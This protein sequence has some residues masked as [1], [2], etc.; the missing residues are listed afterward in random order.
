VVKAPVD[1][2]VESVLDVTCKVLNVPVELVVF[3]VTVSELSDVVLTTTRA[4]R[5]LVPPTTRDAAI[6]TP[7][8]AMIL[9]VV[10]LVASVVELARSD[11]TLS[12]PD[13]IVKLLTDAFCPTYRFLFT[14]K[15]PEL[16]KLPVETLTASD[17][18]VLTTGD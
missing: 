3:P 12:S 18:S 16:E 8:D 11:P 7:P 15:P 4:L 2:L 14:D 9:P 6:P 5:V 10:V 13:L 17:V 1:G